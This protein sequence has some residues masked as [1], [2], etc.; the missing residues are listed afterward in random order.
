MGPEDLPVGTDG[1][2]LEPARIELSLLIRPLRTLN[3]CTVL[4]AYS[5]IS[6][7]GAY[8][9]FLKP[10]KRPA[11]PLDIPPGKKDNMLAVLGGKIAVE[12]RL[13]GKIRTPRI[14]MKIKKAAEIV[15]A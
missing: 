14:L 11:A 1:A 15:M 7:K 13:L 8:A 3:S 9:I 10:K 2:G 12:I 6:R 4:S 5:I